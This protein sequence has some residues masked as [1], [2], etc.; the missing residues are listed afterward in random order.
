M[1]SR[2]RSESESR[3]GPPVTAPASG[4]QPAP[5]QMNWASAMPSVFVIRTYV[6]VSP[7]GT[8]TR[9][10]SLSFASPHVSRVA[11]ALRCWFQ[12]CAR[13]RRGAIGNYPY[14]GFDG[15]GWMTMDD[16]PPA[17]GGYGDERGRGGESFNETS[18]EQVRR[19]SC[20]DPRFA[21][22]PV[23]AGEPTPKPVS[24]NRSRSDS[25]AF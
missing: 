4:M 14:G 5:F 6:V 13:A 20:S 18:A 22:C 9:R 17:C 8:P 1:P 7:A 12:S 23:R 16:L 15:S 21:S 2:S 24:F 10:R 25:V 19:R 3:D 11:S